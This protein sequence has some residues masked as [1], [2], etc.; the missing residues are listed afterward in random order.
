MSEFDPPQ[1][2]EWQ[3]LDTSV[4]E[5][6]PWF[7]KPSLREISTWDIQGKTVV[8][9]GGGNSSLWWA[10]KGAN[11]ITVERSEAWYEQI[12]REYSKYPNKYPTAQIIYVNACEG[13][14]TDLPFYVEA[15]FLV[16]GFNRPDILVVDDI[17]RFEC[18]EKALTLPRPMILIVDNWDQDYVFKCPAAVK[19]MEQYEGKFFVQPDHT[20]HEGSPWTTAIWELT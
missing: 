20:N 15:P 17:F 2:A 6:Y 10:S 13:V 7:T 16:G 5:W 18:I 3:W 14:Q 11:I 1:V 8:E 12:K 9:Y 19:L 4:R